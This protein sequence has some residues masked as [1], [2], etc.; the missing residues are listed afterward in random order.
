MGINAGEPLSEGDDL[1][2]IVVSTAA[3]ICDKAGADEVLVA[4]VVRELASGKGFTFT[5]AGSF[6]LKGLDEPVR[7]YRVSY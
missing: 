6:D 5:D 1:H 7:L 3:R 2:G 4:N